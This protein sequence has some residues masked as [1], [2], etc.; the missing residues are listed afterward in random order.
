MKS[1][2]VVLVTL[3]ACG[4]DGGGPGGADGCSFAVELGGA[5]TASFSATA[6]T[7]CAAANDLGGDPI[8]VFYPEHATLMRFD[9]EFTAADVGKTGPG[10]AGDLAIIT[11]SGAVWDTEC[12][13]DLARWEGTGGSQRLAG[14][15]SCPMPAE[16]DTGTMTID[17]G[18]IAFD[19]F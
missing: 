3:A 12:T 13:F 11:K 17:V 19:M 16:P 9:L 10:I 2:V 5:I 15:A 8:I 1:S 4:G 7:S 18:P 14:T 6:A